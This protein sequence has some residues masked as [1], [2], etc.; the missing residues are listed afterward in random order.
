MI[1]PAS[2]KFDWQFNTKGDKNLERMLLAAKEFSSSIMLGESPRWIS[3][4]GT[5]GAGKSHL[6]KALLR[7]W[8]ERAGWRTI[9]GKGGDFQSLEE[10]VFV[11]W[12]KF[13][14]RQRDGNHGEVYALSKV[15]FVVLDDIGS[16]YDP[17]G[18]SKDKLYK[19]AECRTGK[20]TVV[21][22]NLGLDHIARSIDIR[23]A[24]RMLRDNS[25]VVKVT[26]PDYNLRK[27]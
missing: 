5:S 6:A 12:S 13:I 18:F 24:S 4:L 15:P 21:T 2:D 3:F 11:S 27:D 26:A 8:R 7:F 14:D 10:S 1:T 25:I 17:S 16:E 9:H 23:V 22:S 19:L 20:W